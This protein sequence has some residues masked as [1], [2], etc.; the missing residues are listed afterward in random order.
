MTIFAVVEMR[1]NSR[2]FLFVLERF[3]FNVCVIHFVL[4]CS[5]TYE[6]RSFIIKQERYPEKFLVIY[7]MKILKRIIETKDLFKCL[8]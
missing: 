1:L 4:K 7:I 6:F 8:A 2:L 3:F 5:F